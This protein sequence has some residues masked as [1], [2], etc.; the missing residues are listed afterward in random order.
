MGYAHGVSTGTPLGPR[1]FSGGDK[2]AAH[3]LEVLGFEVQHLPYV[4]WTRDELILA[5]EIMA[6]G[7]WK[8]LPASHPQVIEVSRLLQ[9]PANHP[10]MPRHPDFRNENGVARKTSD[11]A[12]LVDP[13]AL[14]PAPRPSGSPP[15]LSCARQPAPTN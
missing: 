1:D 2:T 10:Y 4:N 7:G 8:P 9:S 11:I 3:R 5:C 15:R 14:H 6:P 12:R 13:L